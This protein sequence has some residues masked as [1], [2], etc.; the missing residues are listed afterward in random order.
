MHILLAMI[1]PTAYI[2]LRKIYILTPG[3]PLMKF[4]EELVNDFKVHN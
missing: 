1:E 3:K 4:Y 2:S